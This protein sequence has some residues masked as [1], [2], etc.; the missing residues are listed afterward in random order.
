[1]ERLT[2][3]V[4]GESFPVKGANFIEIIEQLAKYEDREEGIK[5]HIG[6]TVRCKNCK[7]VIESDNTNRLYCAFHSDGER[8]PDD[9]CS[10]GISK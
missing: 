5:T 2:E 4:K 1:M 6:D 8:M 3:R 10:E 7:Y 9:Y